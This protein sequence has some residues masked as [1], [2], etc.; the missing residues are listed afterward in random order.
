MYVIR[1]AE[2]RLSS[3]FQKLSGK[4]NA[5]WACDPQKARTFP[6]VEKAKAYYDAHLRRFAFERNISYPKLEDCP[7]YVNPFADMI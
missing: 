3:Y 4:T 1:N 5:L 2:T 7:P 6:T